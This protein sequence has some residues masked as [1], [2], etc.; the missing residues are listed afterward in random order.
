MTKRTLTLYEDKG[1]H[2]GPAGDQRV[3]PRPTKISGP[4]H[5]HHNSRAGLAMSC[6]SPRPQKD[7]PHRKR[8][9]H[10]QG[11]QRMVR[12]PGGTGVGYICSGEML[13]LQGWAEIKRG[14]QSRHGICGYFWLWII[15]Y[16]IPDHQTT[17][18]LEKTQKKE[19]TFWKLTIGNWKD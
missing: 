7:C 12:R 1:A 4:Q 19:K 17:I 8:V 15:F 2:A 6:Q 9:H 14:E 13:H 10:R 18:L 16:F 5:N 3:C 11:W